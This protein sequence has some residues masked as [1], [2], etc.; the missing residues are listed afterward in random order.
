MKLVTGFSKDENSEYKT[1]ETVGKALE[2]RDMVLEEVE[3]IVKNNMQII[4]SLLSLQSNVDGEALN[5]LNESE[6]RLKSMAIMHEKLYQSGDLTQVNFKE[7]MESLFRY[8]L[9]SYTGNFGGVIVKMDVEEVFLNVETA[10]PLG[11]TINEIVS[12]RLNY[13]FPDGEGEIK[14][15]L[16]STLKGFEIQISDNGVGMPEGVGP[17]KTRSLGLQLVSALINQ[18]EGSVKIKRDNGAIYTI[19]FRELE[20]KDQV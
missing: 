20:Y 6:L 12:N 2:E 4:S 1:E 17:E 14:V 16:H 5:T 13:A 11:L 18:L 15:K 9:H 10:V 3:R 8:L 7:Y 19:Q